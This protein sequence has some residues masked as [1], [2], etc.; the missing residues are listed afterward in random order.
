LTEKSHEMKLGVKNYAVIMLIKKS[1]IKFSNHHHHH[2]QWL[3]S[4][5]KD[6]G[7]LKPEVS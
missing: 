3:Y 2:H 4:P 7:H 5:C 6:L 1:C